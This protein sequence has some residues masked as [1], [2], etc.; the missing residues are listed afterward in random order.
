MPPRTEQ[1][2][3]RLLLIEH[4]ANSTLNMQ[5]IRPLTRHMPGRKERHHR[6][7]CRRSLFAKLV[8]CPRTA[9][10]LTLREMIKLYFQEIAKTQPEAKR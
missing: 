6:Q 9:G 10:I 4:P 5:V 1:H 8:E 7:R 3:I 2:S